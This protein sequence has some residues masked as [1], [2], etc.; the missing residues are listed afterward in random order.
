LRAFFGIRAN[1]EM[2]YLVD[3]MYK[4]KGKEIVITFGKPISYTIF[5][6][7][8]TDLAWAQKLK[9]HVYELESDNNKSFSTD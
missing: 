4:Q 7:K 5:D 8:Y 3:E 6:K 2:L 1:I 9:S